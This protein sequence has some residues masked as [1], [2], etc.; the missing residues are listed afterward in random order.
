M[1]KMMIQY[2]YIYFH[3]ISCWWLTNYSLYDIRL[4]N[5]RVFFSKSV[6]KSVKHGL[7]F[8]CSHVLEYTKTRTVLQS[9]NISYMY[10]YACYLMFFV[11]LLFPLVAD[12]SLLQQV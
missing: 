8:D 2:M 7:L 10:M 11:H 4:Q 3:V 12:V 6:K 9:N 1:N 5:S